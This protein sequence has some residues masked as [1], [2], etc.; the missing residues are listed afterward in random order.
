VVS[1][2]VARE[3]HPCRKADDALEHQDGAGGVEVDHDGTATENERHDGAQSD[4]TAADADRQPPSSVPLRGQSP[5]K[6]E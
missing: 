6:V 1:T 3:Q 4:Q 5:P 2:P